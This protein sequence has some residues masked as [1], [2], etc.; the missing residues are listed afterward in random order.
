[1]KYMIL[2]FVIG[3]ALKLGIAYALRVVRNSIAKL[4]ETLANGGLS[5]AARDRLVLTVASLAAVGDFLAKLSEIVGTPELPVAAQLNDL[6]DAAEK[7][8]RITDGL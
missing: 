5:D 4:N 3:S 2:K 8:R 1:M 6:N 7:L